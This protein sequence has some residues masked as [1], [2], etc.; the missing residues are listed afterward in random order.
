MIKEIKAQDLSTDTFITEKINE[1]RAAVGSGTAINALS[2]GRGLV[3]CY[4]AG[5]RALGS[6]LRTVFIQNGLMREGEPEAVASRIQE[7]WCHR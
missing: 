6:R 1:I 4:H 7:P 3:G 5:H 2:G